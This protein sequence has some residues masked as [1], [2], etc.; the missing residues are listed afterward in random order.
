MPEDQ[1]PK[2][3]SCLQSLQT[4]SVLFVPGTVTII[5]HNSSWVCMTDTFIHFI[6]CNNSHS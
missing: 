5:I 4:H 6:H 2:F 1:N 3:L